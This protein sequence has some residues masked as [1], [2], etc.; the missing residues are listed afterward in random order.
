[1]KE[2]IGTDD[3]GLQRKKVAIMNTFIC[4]QI[5]KPRWN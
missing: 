5:W 2:N 4:E 3:I 1:M